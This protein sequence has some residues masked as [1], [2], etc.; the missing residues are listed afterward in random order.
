[1]K[2]QRLFNGI[3]AAI[4]LITVAALQSCSNSKVGKIEK[5]LTSAKCWITEYDDEMCGIN[6]KC[7]EIVKF[8]DGKCY[9]S[10]TYS[11]DGVKLFVVKTVCDYSIDYD[12]DLDSY[13]W[14]EGNIEMNNISVSNIN[15]N[16]EWFRKFDTEARVAYR[17]DA[18]QIMDDD[19]DTLYGLEIIDI[20][21]SKMIVKELQ[22]DNV[23]TYQRANLDLL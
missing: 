13:F 23:F 5:T 18:N 3:L 1:M 2:V 20:T 11:Q 12:K 10:F 16:E 6:M 19:D 15:S 17:G 9:Q 21:D 7:T 14:E 22:T 4:L 8:K